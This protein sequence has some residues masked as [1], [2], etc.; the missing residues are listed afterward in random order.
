MYSLNL[1]ERTLLPAALLVAFLLIFSLLAAAP[2]RAQISCVDSTTG[3]V[4]NTGDDGAEIT[5]SFTCSA[6]DLVLVSVCGRYSA[7]PQDPTYGGPPTVTCSGG[8]IAAISGGSLARSGTPTARL[9]TFEMTTSGTS[10]TVT[11][12]ADGE[13]SFVAVLAVYSGASE[14]DAV[15]TA[16]DFNEPMIPDA[17]VTTVSA[18]DMVVGL[19]GSE[20]QGS[21]D[22]AGTGFTYVNGIEVN[23]YPPSEGVL[24]TCEDSNSQS[25]AADTS[26]TPTYEYEEDDWFEVAVALKPS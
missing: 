2:A 26:V 10:G 25:Y 8:T 3:G 12:S 9:D 7:V 20:T 22:P 18:N 13:S 1:S 19:L 5:L 24:T 17:S 6:G 14:V 4:D 16:S 11:V 21:L 15:G 23:L